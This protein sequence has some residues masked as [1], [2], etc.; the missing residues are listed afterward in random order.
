MLPTI[1]QIIKMPV[2]QSGRPEVAAGKRHMHR[3][4][5]WVHVSELADIAQML[6]GGEL[7]LTTGIALADTEEELREYVAALATAGAS[8]LIIELGRRFTT[9]PTSLIRACARRQLPLIVLHRPVEFVRLTETVHTQILH[10]QMAAL[11]LSERAHATFTALSVDGA[12]VTDIVRE[13]AH[14][15]RAPVVFEDLMRRVLAYEPAGRPV[16]MLLQR[17]DVRSRAAQSRARTAVCGPEEWAVTSVEANGDVFGRLIMLPA[18]RATSEELMILERAATALT[19]NRVL[20]RDRTAIEIH[21]QRSILTDLIDGRYR[22]ESEIHSRAASLGISLGK[23]QLVAVVVDGLAHPGDGATGD[24][25]QAVARALDA[26]GIVALLTTLSNGTVG[27]LIALDT[28]GQTP[29]TVTRLATQLRLL[30]P[31]K[32]PLIGM[33]D[34]ITGLDAVRG[35]FS[36]AL[37]I[38]AA[39]RAHPEDKLYFQLPDIRLR[40]LI[41]TFADDP[42]LQAFVERTLS[43][44][45]EFDARHRTDLTAVLRVYL[46]HRAN[47]TEAA[48]A[49]RL[50]RQ[51]FYERLATIAR[52]LE[53]DLGS[54]EVCTSLHAA[55]MG[56]ESRQ[57]PDS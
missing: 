29:A 2:V 7:I 28:A 52:I 34:P 13:A 40:G 16:D 47:K 50:S 41:Y 48:R 38:T 57:H 3:T 46:E 51:S 35:A 26:A 17:W 6:Q 39:A 43:P 20:E 9:P 8:G 14:M 55:L 45:L 12:N 44:L 37:H 36:E 19:L 24:R 4:V 5:R 33:A 18:H 25:L 22:S 54:G 10:E 56:W 49:A 11:Q 15:V 23:R 21:A 1:E 31:Q 27:I 32:P 42:R 30:S 53:V